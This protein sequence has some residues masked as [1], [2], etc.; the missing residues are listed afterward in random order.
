ML[1]RIIVAAVLFAAGGLLHLEGWVE[2]GVYLVCYAVI[3]WDIVWKAITNILHG[4]V[5][6]ENFLMTIATVGALILGEHSEGVAVMLFYQVGEWFQS[7]AVSKSRRSITSLMDIRPD[8]ANIEK[9][10]KLIQV[11][12]EDVKIGDTIIVKPGERV[13][14]DGKIIK[15]SSTLDTSA[16]TGE[17]MPREVE[18]GMEVISGCINQTGIL[19]IQTTKEFGESTVAKILDL[20]ENASDKKGRMENFITRFARYYTPVVVFAALALAVL[21][22]LVTGQAFS[23]WIYRALTFLVISCPCALVISIPL[24]FFGGI[25][26]ASKIGVLVKGSNYL[27]ALAYT[28]TVVFDKTGTLTKGSFAV[29]EIQANGM[30]DEDLLEL[31]AYAELDGLVKKLYEANATGKL[32][33]KHFSRLLA[34]YD[35]EQAALEASMTEWQELIDNWNADRLKMAEFID[36]AKR[37][38]DF[39]ELTTPMLNEFIEKIVVHEGNGRGKQRRQRLDFYFNFI[40]AFEVPADVVTPM[41]QE[42]ERRQQEEQAEKEER[43]KALAQARYER[44]KQERREFTARK[45]AGLL[46]PEEQAEEERRL[47]RNR[48]YQKK[49]RDKKKASQPEKPRKRS[50][51]ELAKLDRAGADLTPE[52][53]ERLAAYKQR[54]AE[55][56]KRCREKQQAAQPPKPQQRTLKELAECAEAGLPLTPEEVERLE[57]HRNRKKAALQDLKARAE[58]DPAAAAELA[59]QRA[60]QSEAVKKSRQKMYA[61]AAAGDPEAQARYERFLATKR[62]NYHRKKQTEAEAA[63]AT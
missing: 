39:S 4:Q 11:D 57:A 1:T 58:T 14:L 38:T 33:D 36:L 35:E 5:F 21:P 22:P 48:A 29:T 9:D 25:G 15:G 50:L 34:G 2:L 40:G 44:Y 63:Q 53:A 51:E 56:V 32:P 41:E 24:S 28:E 62:E 49:Q 20:V 8:Y 27:E 59:Q 17:S 7:Y 12:P 26:G 43:S 30:T 19:T 10:G 54:K 16:L 13:P 31:A 37:Y 42:E 6:D 45:R 46:T 3:G 61:D 47:E 18:T 60:Q 52:E 23:I 55:A